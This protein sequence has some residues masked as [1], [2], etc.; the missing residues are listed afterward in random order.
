LANYQA[1]FAYE[2]NFH[3]IENT[4]PSASPAHRDITLKLGEQVW[5]AIH[6]WP[7]LCSG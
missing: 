3:Y 5:R 6:G 7:L 4:L 1:L 2:W